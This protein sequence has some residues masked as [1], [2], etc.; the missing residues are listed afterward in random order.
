MTLIKTNAGLPNT[1]S[2]CGGDPG[3]TWWAPNDDQAR[4]GQGKCDACAN[5]KSGKKEVPAPENQDEKQPEV[6]QPEVPA[7]APEVKQPK[8]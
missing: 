6:K 3:A 2:V 5:P 7:P 1:C 8:G 4:A